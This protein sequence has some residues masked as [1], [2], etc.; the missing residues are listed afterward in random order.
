MVSC[1]GGRNIEYISMANQLFTFTFMMGD[2]EWSEKFVNPL[3]KFTTMN[4]WE[5]LR[6]CKSLIRT[7]K[8]DSVNFSALAVMINPVTYH[9]RLKYMTEPVSDCDCICISIWHK[10]VG[11]PRF[12]YPSI[13]CIWNMSFIIIIHSGLIRFR[14]TEHNNST[15]G[16]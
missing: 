3:T 15:N 8:I 6:S 14:S 11:N 7:K 12:N 2:G 4:S 10:W 9:Y 13:T 1:V 16:T 5:P